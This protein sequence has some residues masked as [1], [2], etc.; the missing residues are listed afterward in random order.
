[1]NNN[2][3]KTLTFPGDKSISHRLVLLSLL[4]SKTLV[5]TNLS[6][7]KDVQTSLDIVKKLGVEVRCS[8]DGKTVVL[9][10]LKRKDFG[11]EE[12]ILDCGNSG[13]TARLLC[14]ILANLKGRFKLIGDESLSKRPMERVVR[15][16]ADLMRVNIRSTDGHLPIYIEA[17][18]KTKAADFFN[19][20]GSAQVKS[21]DRK[22]VV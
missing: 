10:P 19:K 5:I 4:I 15:P 8:D 17:K 3:I 9:S 7:S 16:L 21:A 14:G 11:E 12:I 20:T 18:G 2:P 1:M 13:T 6:S 22:S